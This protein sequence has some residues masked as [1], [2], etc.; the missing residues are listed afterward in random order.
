MKYSYRLALFVLLVFAFSNCTKNGSDKANYYM[1]A[2]VNGSLL[3]LTNTAVADT[4]HS[5]TPGSVSYFILAS[6]IGGFKGVRIVW[7]NHQNHTLLP[8]VY[9]GLDHHFSLHVI[10][11]PDG[12]QEY[13]NLAFSGFSV[14]VHEINDCFIQGSFSG[15]LLLSPTMQD[16]VRITN[17][18][19]KLPFSR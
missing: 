16:S 3:D 10:Y 14:A 2:E 12:V 4:M 18:K 17:G 11:T 8:A 9:T 7:I 19:F 1:S 6:E 15:V 13:R 5:P